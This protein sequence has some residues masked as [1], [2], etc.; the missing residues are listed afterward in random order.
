MC[1]FL[2]LAI[3]QQAEQG[4]A[5]QDRGGMMA[6]A[7]RLR[8][9]QSPGLAVLLGLPADGFSAGELVPEQQFTWVVC[10]ICRV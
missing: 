9:R 10:S 2:L 8:S 4:R 3:P 7:G 6:L 1:G 5:G